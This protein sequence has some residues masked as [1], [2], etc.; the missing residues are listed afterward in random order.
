M[1]PLF[2]NTSTKNRKINRETLNKN[3]ILPYFITTGIYHMISV[4][5]IDNEPAVMDV[6]RLFPEPDSN[7]RVT[8]TTPVEAAIGTRKSCTLSGCG[9]T[10][11]TDCSLQGRS[12]VLPGLSRNQGCMDRVHGLKS[13]FRQ[14]PDGPV[15]RA[16]TD[17]EIFLQSGKQ[18][19]EGTCD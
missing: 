11:G 9:K 16:H 6:A 3:P 10:P 15:H 13:F 7:I 5:H 17:R 12:P 19:M 4:L 2:K 14:G 8:T 18:V 1:S